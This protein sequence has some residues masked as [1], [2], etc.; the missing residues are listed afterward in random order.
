MP[1]IL[2][3]SPFAQAFYFLQTNQRNNVLLV[4]YIL[5]GVP[6]RTLMEDPIKYGLQNLTKSTIDTNYAR[7]KAALKRAGML[8]NE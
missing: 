8:P 7:K 5:A 4:A 6:P 1:E 2:Q 3:D